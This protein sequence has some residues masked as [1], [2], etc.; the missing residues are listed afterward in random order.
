MTISRSSAGRRPN[1]RR[2]DPIWRKRSSSTSWWAIVRNRLSGSASTGPISRASASCT[3]GSYGGRSG[4]RRGMR[5]TLLAPVV[6]QLQDGEERLLGNLDAPDLLHA[7]L[8]LLLAL[9]E[10]ALAADVA[11][12]ALG[13]D[14]LAVGLDGLAGDDVRADR[15]LDRHVVLL[16]GDA[17]AQLLGQRAAELVGLVAVDDHRERVHGIAR[18]QHVELDE[19]GR[20]HAEQLVIQ[21]RVA[22]RARLELVEEVQDDLRQRQVVGD[23]HA[24][25]AEEVHARVLA[26][27][28]LAELHHGADVLL[29]G[30]DRGLDVGLADLGDAG[31]VGVD[32]RAV[33]LELRAVG[34]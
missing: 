29:A 33:H 21:R 1:D 12:V 11:A 7:L 9:E 16:A 24:V 23:L 14:V 20:P 13:R 3:F 25:G 22:A 5:A 34:E 26:A 4:S 28:L 10:L 30:E 18:Q 27:A 32:G 6:A 17:G 2:R 31:R 15:G 19:V 8:A